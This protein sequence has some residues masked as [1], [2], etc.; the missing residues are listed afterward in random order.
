MK[1][2]N[3]PS[4]STWKII[5]ARLLWAFGLGLMIEIIDQDGVE[6]DLNKLSFSFFPDGGNL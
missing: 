5:T 1:S 2:I 6:L 4:N 3:A